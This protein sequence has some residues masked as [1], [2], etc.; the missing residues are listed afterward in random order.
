[1]TIHGSKVQSSAAAADLRQ[2]AELMAA[3]A[4][5]AASSGGRFVSWTRLYG[6]DPHLS[7]LPGSWMARN[8]LVVYWGGVLYA[9]SNLRTR[10]LAGHQDEVF[11]VDWSSDGDR[12]VSGSKDK[13]LRIWKH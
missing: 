3:A 1:M 4:A 2:R 12:L 8:E 10:T 5:A 7:L 13:T 11:A 9:W 6:N